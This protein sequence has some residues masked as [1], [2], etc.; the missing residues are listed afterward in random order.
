MSFTVTLT[1]VLVMFLYA[2]PGYIMMKS[3]LLKPEAIGP[4]V[5]ILLYLSAP[6][7]TI[8]AMQQITPTPDT[9]KNL[10]LSALLALM[11]MGVMLAAVYL[12]LR[13]RQEDVT[14]RI[15][16]AAAACGNVGFIGIPLLEALLPNY[17]QA[18]A[19]SSVFS[20]AM[21]ILMWTV[22]SF[23]ITRDRKYMSVRKIFVNPQSIAM[24]VALVLL[25]AGIHF[26][27]Q[28]EGMVSLLGRMATPLC[29]LILGMRLA[30]IP[31]KPMFTRPINYMA[32]ALK[33]VVFPL[34]ALCL[35]KLL[36]VDRDFTAAIYILC[37][38]PVANVVLSFAEML[39]EGQECAAGVMLLSTILSVVTI[40]LMTRLI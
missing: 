15:C 32:I 28:I 2:L 38:V 23:I 1:T 16:T 11:L 39:G 35:C 14:Y 21:N 31:I 22:V 40:P 4:T 12:A 9:L 6:L 33:M 36:P 27:G 8:Y 13:K 18:L 25:M 3:R 20:V 30:L 26:T 19:F 37:C 7:Q 34:A 29:M 10:G 24:A 17:P 5:T